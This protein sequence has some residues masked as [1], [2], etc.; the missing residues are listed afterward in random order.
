MDFSTHGEHA[1]FGICPQPGMALAEHV[2]NPVE[3]DH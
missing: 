3:S 1:P 2:R